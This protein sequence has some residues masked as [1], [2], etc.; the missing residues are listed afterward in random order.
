MKE[1]TTTTIKK[2]LNQNELC[3]LST[4]SKTGKSQSA[5]MAYAFDPKTWAFYLFTEDHTRKFKN[6]QQNSKVS[7]VIGGFKD[8]PSLQIDGT[9]KIVSGKSVST[10]KKFILSLH[11]EWKDYFT[12]P[13][14]RFLKIKPA[15]LRYGDYSQGAPQIA[16]I[17]DF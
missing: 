7:L 2:Y 3:V 15:W 6:L 10:V 1:L 17:S 9:V 12:N 4:A 13:C 14:N 8:D 5:V 16:Q 11:P